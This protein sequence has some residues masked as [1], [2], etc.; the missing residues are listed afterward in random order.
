VKRPDGQRGSFSVEAMLV[1]TAC[2]LMIAGGVRMFCALYDRALL[3]FLAWQTADRAARDW[4]AAKTGLYA[5]EALLLTGPQSYRGTFYSRRD[6]A[7]PG[8]EQGDETG[9][10]PEWLGNTR[11]DITRSADQLLTQSGIRW[12]LTHEESV[13]S[14]SMTAEIIGDGWLETEVRGVAPTQTPV[15]MIRKV[16]VI[17]EKGGDLLQMVKKEL[18]FLQGQ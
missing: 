12:T 13:L 15:G 3:E 6:G 8:L 1:F 10:W 16:D 4:N 5:E 18:P 2:L 7:G 11:T 17:L 14:G 9:S